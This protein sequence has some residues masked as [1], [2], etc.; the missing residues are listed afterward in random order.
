MR[1]GSPRGN[2]LI[3]LAVPRNRSTTETS[4]ATGSCAVFGKL[5]ST[6][7]NVR[8]RVSPAPKRGWRPNLEQ[9]EDRT[10]PTVTSAVVAG[11]LTIDGTFNDTI[12]VSNSGGQVKIN[13]ADPGS[14]A[15]AANTVTHI[16]V[17]TGA[18]L[19]S[20]DL[21]NVTAA[22]FGN[23]LDFHIFGGAGQDTYRINDEF[24]GTID[25]GA[26]ANLI[27]VTGAAAD[28]ALD[29][30]NNTLSIDGVAIALT[31]QAANLFL[32][33]SI[34]NLEVDPAQG[35]AATLS[36]NGTTNDG[37]SRISTLAG[38]AFVDFRNPSAVLKIKDSAAAPSGSE[39]N[40]LGLDAVGSN[41][42][43]TFDAN[44]K[45][46]TLSF[47]G[48]FA[49]AVADIPNDR[50][51]LDGRIIKLLNA[52]ASQRHVLGNVAN[53]TVNSLGFKVEDAGAANDGISRLTGTSTGLVILFKNPSASLTLTNASG[54]PG[55]VFEF[56]DLDSLLPPAAITVDAGGN[57]AQLQFYRT[58]V[59][60]VV[61]QVQHRVSLDSLVFNVPNADASQVTFK[62]P[63]TNFTFLP[64]LGS[65]QK[66]LD[67]GNPADSI[68]TFLNPTLSSTVNF[69]NPTGT[70]TIRD[71]NVSGGS[72]FEFEGTD[73]TSAISN[74]V[75]DAAGRADLLKFTFAASDVVADL[76]LGEV[77]LDGVTVKTP[78]AAAANFLF[79]IPMDDFTLSTPLSDHR[80]VQDDGSD[81]DGISRMLNPTNG[82]HVDFRNPT[83][84]VTVRDQNA[85]GSSTFEFVTLDSFQ[86]SSDIDLDFGTNPGKA[87]LRVPGFVS[88]VTEDR[89]A[90]IIDIDNWS[91]GVFGDGPNKITLDMQMAALAILPDA[92]DFFVIS[93]NATPN[94]GFS[95][96]SST[97]YGTTTE[98]R[99]PIGILVVAGANGAGGSIYEFNGLDAVNRPQA[100]EL[101]VLSAVDLFRFTGKAT[102]VIDD[103]DN[104]SITIDGLQVDLCGCGVDVF[105]DM[106]MANLS[107]IL[108]PGEGWTISDDGIP[109]NGV[110]ELVEEGSPY[111]NDFR[112]PSAK[113]AVVQDGGSWGKLQGLDAVGKPA[114]QDMPFDSLSKLRE[115]YGFHFAGDYYTSFAG[116]NEK[117]FQDRTGKWYAVF[118][119]GRLAIWNG[120]VQ[121]T[122]IANV[123]PSVYQNPQLLFHAAVTLSAGDLTHLDQVQQANGF[124][125]GG[126]YWENYLGQHEKWFRNQSNQWYVIL[127]SGD[128]KAW[129]GGS[130]LG[131]AVAT[132]NPFAFDDPSV[133][134]RASLT[135]AVVQQ[136]QQVQ[137]AN[138]F[139]FMTTFYDD[140]L[141]LG[142][143]W[144]VDR[145]GAWNVIVANGNISKWNG[146][147]SLSFVVAVDPA[148]YA[149]PWLLL[150]A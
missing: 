111:V 35:N 71:I 88:S 102:S 130:S 50:M 107:F 39:F 108:P 127:P 121:F 104:D 9:M 114:Q 13:G 22:A 113:L 150:Q 67:N 69:V 148:A 115:Q 89:D 94:D 44:G 53:F 16:N 57:V 106:D 136:L 109:N 10:T 61:D 52:A 85:G 86:A 131:A 5:F 27:Q 29:Q 8:P 28:V 138:G 30:I 145:N 12:S 103:L 98:F 75:F 79:D 11:V 20:V 144:F 100:V 51:L 64:A 56:H 147:N 14:G 149:D 37:I 97:I 59:N 38:G 123:D 33:M 119:T 47:N 84:L 142:E 117:W 58:A 99:N 118:A 7:T 63:S 31:G 49:N 2:S 43:V 143:K 82:T 41:F 6:K 140:Y 21:R 68:S 74:I 72:T 92:N 76:R 34:A 129:L 62:N 146:G 73:P 112:N 26:Q 91:V 95:R 90:K 101:D 125:F 133:L 70:L 81:G 42:G 87:I 137:Q 93:D 25:S 134:F 17:T 80:I 32:D 23:L 77:S 110:S 122:T 19:N 141:G 139:R 40:Y 55:G 78:N 45:Q 96:G 116:Q 105:L 132:V 15:A 4:F 65:Y 124:H 1:V 54:G 126:S 48:A 36:D 60:A 83:N 24:A 46:T 135:P 3:Q 66:L 18:G 128:I 120:G